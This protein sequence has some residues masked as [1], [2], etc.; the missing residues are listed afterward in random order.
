MR[1]TDNTILVTNGGSGIG[2]CLA[3]ALHHAGNRP[4]MHGP[5]DAFTMT[6]DDFVT[7][8]LWLISAEPEADEVVVS[9]AQGLPD[10][11]R[12]GVY[13]EQFAAVNF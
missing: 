7:E 1:L 11:Q 10:A 12:N 9:A 6:V 13:S 5:G 3:V 4:E 2:R 8:V